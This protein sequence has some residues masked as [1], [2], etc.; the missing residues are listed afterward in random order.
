V[1]LPVNHFK[2]K[3]KGGERQIGIWSALASSLTAEVLAG[4]GFDWLLIDAE[5]G[6][7]EVPLVLGQLQACLGSLTHPIV[8][9]P[10]NDAVVI[11]RLLDVGVQTF[12]VPQVQNVE[13]AQRAV[14]ATRY[15]PRGVRGLAVAT[16]ASRFGRIAGYHTRCEEELCVLVQLETQVALAN[17]EAIAAVDGVDGVFIGPGDLSADLGFAGQPAHPQVQSVIDNA[18]RRIQAAGARAGIL[19]PDE[20]L[21]RRYL[22]LGCCFVAVGSDIGILAR[23]AEQLARRFKAVE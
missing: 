12:L 3:L 22:E 4:A 21:A 15:P 23:T 18:V 6:P 11:K 20:Q 10:W 19:T 2:R 1:D 5:H 7:N 9:P 16:R 13:E 14:A 17:L 8:R